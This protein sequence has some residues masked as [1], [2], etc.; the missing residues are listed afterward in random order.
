MSVYV[1]MI[2]SGLIELKSLHLHELTII[3]QYKFNH[4]IKH[5]MKYFLKIMTRSE[6]YLKLI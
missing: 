4:K 1:L 6:I 3:M 2:S 5:K